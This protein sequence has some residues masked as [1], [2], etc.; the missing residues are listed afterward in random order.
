MYKLMFSFINGAYCLTAIYY[1]L[2][3][4]L[5][6]VISFSVSSSN[7]QFV[8]GFAVDVFNIVIFKC[9]TV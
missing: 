5:L 2:T 7:V 3:H 8:S 6:L 1:P 4:L 9:F